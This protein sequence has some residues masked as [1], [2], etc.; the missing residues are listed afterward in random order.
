MRAHMLHALVLL[1]ETPQ[2]E[3]AFAVMEADERGSTAMRSTEAVLHLAQANPQA[4]R[5]VLAS[6][7]DASWSDASRS[8]ESLSDMSRSDVS[9]AGT[10]PVWTVAAFLL[11]ATACEALGDSD[12][13]GT[14]LGRA[15]ETAEPDHV[16]LPF[17]LHP[18]RD[19]LKRHAGRDPAHRALIEEI[20]G[21]L[22]A[23]V[24]TPPRRRGSRRQ[25]TCA[26]RSAAARRAY[27]DTCRPTC[28]RRRSQRS[29][30]CQSI[31][32]ARTCAR[33][34][35]ARCPQPL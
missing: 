19:L 29:C 6:R 15:L 1:G 31:P 27:C 35:E 33:L 3:Q 16:L 9:S 34:R 8:G 13:A 2:V 28:P 20:L 5:D 18:A 7:S 22:W 25:H 21:R 14:A 32:S 26:I 12:E 10:H 24:R 11:E 23:T 4:A 17:L 30:R